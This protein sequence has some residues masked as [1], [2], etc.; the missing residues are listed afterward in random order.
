[1]VHVELNGA[2][3][4]E[5]FQSLRVRRFALGDRV[6]R[7]DLRHQFRAEQMADQSLGS[8]PVVVSADRAA[9]PR[10]VL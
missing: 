1:M 9:R 2:G 4:R 7:D 8:I 10:Q 3:A 5:S 6:W